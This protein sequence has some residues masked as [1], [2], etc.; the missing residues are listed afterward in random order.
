MELELVQERAW[1]AAMSGD[2][3]ASEVVVRVIE[4]RCRLLGV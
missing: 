1:P 2:I 4:E 3:K